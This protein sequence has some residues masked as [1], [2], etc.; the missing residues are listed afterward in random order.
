MPA[1]RC[2]L[3]LRLAGK[4]PRRR[5]PVN[6]A[7]GA[8]I[9][10]ASMASHPERT[11]YFLGQL[12]GVEDL[13]REQS[14]LIARLRR[15]N[16][17]AHG[18]GVA[19][20][21]HVAVAGETLH[22]DPGLAIDCEGNELELLERVSLDLSHLQS[23]TYLGLLFTETPVSPTPS[24]SGIRFAATRE[25]AK[26][27]LESSNSSSGH[28]GKGP[29][30]PGCGQRHPITLARLSK[31]HGAWRVRLANYRSGA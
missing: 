28:S 29:G 22:V 16:R 14:Y 12:L 19:S 27:V 6:S 8:T 2:L 21:L 30:T 15:H 13:T 23:P 4:A 25:E 10:R 9:H 1:R 31:H 3:I 26:V 11:N 5:R 17:F 20:G 7:L 18:W 24:K